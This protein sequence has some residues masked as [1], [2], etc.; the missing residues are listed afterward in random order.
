MN[1]AFKAWE[2][3]LNCWEVNPF[4]VGLSP[5]D[6]LYGTDDGGSTSSGYMWTVILYEQ[7]DEELNPFYSLPAHAKLEHIE[8]HLLKRFN[9]DL[10]EYKIAKDMFSEICM[11]FAQRTLKLHED[12]LIRQ[13]N[14]CRD[15]PLTFDTPD[16]DSKTRNIPGTAKQIATLQK[17]INSLFKELVVLKEQF[18]IEKE[19]AV[20]K[21]GRKETLSEKGL[22]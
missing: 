19:E 21:G 2:K 9:P 12:N 18:Q 6:K 10:P 20:L 15:T 16:P 13:V 17:S 7:N 8:T 1:E 22:I 14:L 4:L 3:D 5:F 11:S